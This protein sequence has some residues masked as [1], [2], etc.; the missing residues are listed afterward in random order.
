MSEQPRIIELPDGARIMARVT[1]L[2]PPDDLFGAQAAGGA[3]GGSQGWGS[4]PAPPEVAYPGTP[5]PAAGVPGS[6]SP[7]ADGPAAHGWENVGAWDT[8]VARVEGLGDIVTGVAHWLRDAA[9]DA[10]PDEW[11]VT[12]GVE[13]A[14]RPGKAVALLADGSVGANLSVTLTWRRES[15]PP[16]TGG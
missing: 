6:R 9:K 15:G 7:G 13:L 16:Q 8:V 14:A 11:Q 12:F 10:A 1:R 3:A 4:E 5:A 2:D